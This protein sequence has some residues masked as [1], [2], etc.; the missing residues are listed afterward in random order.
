M[1]RL[2]AILVVAGLALSAYLLHR[3][4]AAG[5]GAAPGVWSL[6]F[7]INC[8][9]ALTGAWSVVAGIPLAGWGVI[10][11]GMLGTLLLLAV[12]VGAPFT[13][14]AR[15]AAALLALAGAAASA[16]LVAATVAGVV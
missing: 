4:F 16:V 8:D 13:A 10:Q 14:V 3:H 1:R 11:F 9:A 5:Q 2:S 15:R 12:P 7:D 6:V